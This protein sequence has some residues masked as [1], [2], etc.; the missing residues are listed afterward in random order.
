MKK[1]STSISLPR[2]FLLLPFLLLT[3][4]SASPASAAA[5]IVYWTPDTIASPHAKGFHIPVYVTT[6]APATGCPTGDIEVEIEFIASLFFPRSVTNGTIV[7]NDIVGEKRIIGI[8]LSGSAA[9]TNGRLTELVGD[10]LLGHSQSTPLTL[11]VRCAGTPVT[12]S[13]YSGAIQMGE[14]FCEEGSDRLLSYTDGFGITKI[15]PNPAH[16]SVTIALRTVELESTSLE[17][18]STYGDRIFATT[19]VP[20]STESGDM[21]REIVLP[22]DLPGGLYQ[23]VLRSPGRRDS[24][25]LIIAK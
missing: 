15:A 2:A 21:Y 17:L 12:D 11:R 9:I 1:I 19:W 20:A 14:G 24:K 16:G 5:P 25:T 3:L 7:R 23:V 6:E 13:I 18:Y 8:A 22:P 4:L 10:V